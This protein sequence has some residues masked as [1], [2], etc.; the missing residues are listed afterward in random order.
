M[1]P[2]EIREI[3]AKTISSL[4]SQKYS[5]V[6]LL[7]AHD[8]FINRGLADLILSLERPGGFIFDLKGRLP[9]H[10]CVVRL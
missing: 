10:E 3:D 4:D 7:V 1:L 8:Y 2:P 9:K 6:V 5:A